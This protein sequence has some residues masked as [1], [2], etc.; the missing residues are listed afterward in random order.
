[1]FRTLIGAVIGL[2]V[3]CLTFQLPLAYADGE[4]LEVTTTPPGAA[5]QVDG[6]DKGLSPQLIELPPGGH[7]LL[8]TKKNYLKYEKSFT[9]SAGELKTIDLSLEVDPAHLLR[10]ERQNY[11]SQYQASYKGYSKV[12]KKIA[13]LKGKL[14][15]RVDKLPGYEKQALSVP[16]LRPIPN[17]KDSK[18][19]E[20]KV[21]PG[22]ILGLIVML[23]FTI[24]TLCIMTAT[25]EKISIKKS[26]VFKSAEY[27]RDKDRVENLN[28]AARREA[29]ERNRQ[30]KAHNQ[31]VE[32]VLAKQNAA[33]DK[34]NSIIV[35]QIEKIRRDHGI[36]TIKLRMDRLASKII[37]VSR[38]LGESLHLPSSPSYTDY[39]RAFRKLQ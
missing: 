27:K 16:H 17:R 12:Q 36:E 31:K 21:S 10:K 23:P 33:I 19:Y 32:Q 39:A 26:K 20:K 11:I 5:I 8:V 3:L 18:Y 34:Q 2:L 6:E 24:A 29:D 37:G 14:L 38:Q 35:Q 22:V 25:G 4:M 30:I 28:R 9:I 1:M 15:Q 7:S 13:P